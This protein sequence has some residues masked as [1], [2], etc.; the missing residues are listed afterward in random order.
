MDWDEFDRIKV[1][2]IILTELSMTELMLLIDLLT[3]LL[4][5]RKLG[6]QVNACS[7]KISSFRT[8]RWVVH[9][10][11]TTCLP[12]SAR[13]QECCGQWCAPFKTPTL[14]CWG[15]AGQCNALCSD[16]RWPQVRW[17][18]WINYFHNIRGRSSISTR[19]TPCCVPR[20]TYLKA[21]LAFIFGLFSA[22]NYR[23]SCVCECI[24][25]DCMTALF[26]VPG[27]QTENLFNVS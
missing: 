9:C 5:I 4:G 7:L 21:M 22:N 6:K 1:T 17:A 3:I 8:F 20:Q 12:L 18:L 15:N 16:R 2:A 27:R 23:I 25:L 26:L 24:S 14:S 11:K 13:I 19:Q 10:L